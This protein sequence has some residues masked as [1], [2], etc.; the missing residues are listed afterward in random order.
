MCTIFPFASSKSAHVSAVEFG[1]GISRADTCR[2]VPGAGAVTTPVAALACD[3]EPDVFAKLM[4][5]RP[6]A[7]ASRRQ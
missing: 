4:V 5:D 2:P 7:I 1:H 3:A 6:T